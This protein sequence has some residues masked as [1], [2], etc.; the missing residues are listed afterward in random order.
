MRCLAV[1]TRNVGHVTSAMS[2]RAED[3]LPACR[4]SSAASACE[5]GRDGQPGQCAQDRGAVVGACGRSSPCAAT[6]AI[7]DGGLAFRGRGRDC[8]L[9]L[10][11]R[12]P[13]GAPQPPP[14]PLRLPLPLPPPSQRP[15][16]TNKA[17]AVAPERR[18]AGR[19]PG[20]AAAARG[21]VP[22]RSPPPR[23]GVPPAVVGEP[24]NCRLPPGVLVPAGS[25]LA[26]A[27]SVAYCGCAPAGGLWR[28]PGWPLVPLRLR[29]T[30]LRCSGGG[31]VG[32]TPPVQVQWRVSG[33]SPAARGTKAGGKSSGP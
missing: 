28:P 14:S 26:S 16:P 11:A 22:T 3:S 29:R 19:R 30:S 31:E 10:A 12:P 13:S 15:R 18:G 6:R 4:E 7:R 33:V 24:L 20:A 9:R 1:A 25:R 2:C 32:T 17:S 5:R 23:V 21:G 8:R 27:S